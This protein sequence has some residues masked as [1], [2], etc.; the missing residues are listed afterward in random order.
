MTKTKP[1]YSNFWSWLQAQKDRQ[2]RIGDLARDAIS[3]TAR[4]PDDSD[5]KVWREHLEDM[6]A[7]QAALETL[8]IAWRAY[9]SATRAK[10]QP[11]D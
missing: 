4:P 1:Q 2:D 6:N 8:R 9:K 7:S 11:H 5:Y 10:V 3:D